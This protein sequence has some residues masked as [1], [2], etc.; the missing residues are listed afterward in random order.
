MD[1]HI[2][3]NT[4]SIAQR[5]VTIHWTGPLD[6]NTRLSYFPFLDKFLHLFI[7]RSLKQQIA[8][9]IAGWLLWI[10]VIMTIVFS[11]SAMHMQI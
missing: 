1:T 5:A 3:T 4:Y 11:I 10:D 8:T 9:Y 7:E 6:W 2:C